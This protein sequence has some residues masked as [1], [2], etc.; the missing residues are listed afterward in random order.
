MNPPQATIDG[1]P[2]DDWAEA[3]RSPDPAV[4]QQA[5]RILTQ[6]HV[7]PSQSAPVLIAALSDAD[8]KVRS[9][10]RDFFLQLASQLCRLRS[11]ETVLKEEL[12]KTIAVI[13][14]QMI[15]LLEHEKKRALG[16][17][18]LEQGYQELEAVMSRLRHDLNKEFSTVTGGTELLRMKL[19]QSQ[20]PSDPIA[21]V[22][23]AMYNS[24]VKASMHVIKASLQL[25]GLV[26][27]ARVV[28][29]DVQL[30]PT[31]L[32]LRD[33]LDEVRRGLSSQETG[34][35]VRWD[36]G[37]LPEVIAD[38]RL[39]RVVVE[40]LLSNALKFTRKRSEAVIEVRATKTSSGITCCVRDNGAGFDRRYAEQLFQPFFRLDES[41]D[42]EGKGIGLAMV[43]RIVA[44][45][46]GET[47]AEG[48]VDRG[49]AF[50]FSLPEKPPIC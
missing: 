44:R 42:Y 8:E 5:A 38:P 4:R 27:I 7:P 32:R 11:Q 3:L 19:K 20:T 6:P 18:Q 14:A 10:V 49:A 33:L 16:A 43:K 34:R 45:H 1:R 48:E 28:H 31:N 12:T 37:N 47:W 35:K 39:L 22:L 41:K 2:I 15:T 36:I 29:A 24:I 23:E 21:R 9:I 25:D 17:S 46:G 13:E 40:N 26:E 50:Y 30:A